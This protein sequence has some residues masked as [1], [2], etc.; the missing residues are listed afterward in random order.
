[1][2]SV[3]SLTTITTR[4][5]LNMAVPL[6]QVQ[7]LADCASFS[8]TLSPFLWELSALPGRLLDA[9]T[10][11][12]SWKE[13]YLTTNPFIAALAFAIFLCPI[14]LVTSEV[15]RNWSQVDRL[16]SILPAVYNVHFAVWAR[17]NGLSTQKLDTIAIISV[18]WSVRDTIT[19]VAF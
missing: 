2:N 4:I 11:L 13:V 3:T 5:V 17:Q 18:I 9:G 6:P 19:M 7:S 16:W 12:T 14:F 15:N 10:D 8:H 1:M